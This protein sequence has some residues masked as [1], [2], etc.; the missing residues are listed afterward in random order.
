[1]DEVVD[2]VPI[3]RARG[4]DRLVR[5]VR[6]A[7]RIE[8]AG[9][10]ARDVVRRV[11]N[12]DV[13]PNLLL[14]LHE[15]E[16]PVRDAMVVEPGGRLR[17]RGVVEVADREPV[18]DDPD[19]RALVGELP[20][21][22]P[23]PGDHPGGSE[24]VALRD[25]EPVETVVLLVGGDPPLREPVGHV[26]RQVIERP[27]EPLRGHLAHLPVE[28][29]AD[30]VEVDTEDQSV[31][32]TGRAPPDHV[33]HV[34][35]DGEAHVVYL[36]LVVHVDGEALGVHGQGRH[37]RGEPFNLGHTQ[38]PRP[39]RAGSSAPRGAGNGYS[40]M[41]VWGTSRRLGRNPVAAAPF[42]SSRSAAGRSSVR[43]FH[44]PGSSR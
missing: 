4:G 16:V 9:A 29:R 7:D 39:D 23:R 40:T 15:A 13:R 5:A 36:G 10:Q 12:V 33:A 8:V 42:S 30:T 26:L 38:V 41:P 18:G 34:D 2:L 27:L 3:V 22:P 28:I 32:R 44:P 31:Q 1:M 43:G 6:E 25:G 17:D 35:A 19:P 20:Q 21:D 24:E 37:E 14:L 11:V